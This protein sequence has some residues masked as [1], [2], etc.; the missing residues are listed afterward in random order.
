MKLQ[1]V[2]NTINVLFE[3]LSFAHL[4]FLFKQ[5]CPVMFHFKTWRKVKSNCQDSK[6]LEKKTLAV[7]QQESNRIPDGKQHLKAP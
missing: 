4:N 3:S 7:L 1:N 5:K 2:P 6:D